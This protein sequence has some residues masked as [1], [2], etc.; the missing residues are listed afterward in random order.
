M[1]LD[2]NNI[3]KSLSDIVQENPNDCENKYTKIEMYNKSL[4]MAQF[5][6]QVE[7][8]IKQLQSAWD[9]L[10]LKMINS[11]IKYHNNLKLSEV[12]EECSDKLDSAFNSITEKMPTLINKINNGQQVYNQ[13]KCLLVKLQDNIDKAVFN[14]FKIDADESLEKYNL[15]KK[16]TSDIEIALQYYNSLRAYL[17]KLITWEKE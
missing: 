12:A 3:Y 6:Q 1:T 11:Q 5:M 17:I 15:I 2:T 7:D 9:K 4:T 8:K 16:E 14:K 10:S 13:L